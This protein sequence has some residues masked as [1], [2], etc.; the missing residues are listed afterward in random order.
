MFGETTWKTYGEVQANY[1]AFGRG[2]RALGMEP[3]P[4][5]TSKVKQHAGRTVM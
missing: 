3:L 2:L 5:A 1:E 4:V